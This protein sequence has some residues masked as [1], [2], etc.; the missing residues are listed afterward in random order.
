MSFGSF[1]VRP[2]DGP[3][4]LYLGLCRKYVRIERHAHK[5]EDTDLALTTPID[6]DLDNLEL[7][8]HNAAAQAYIERQCAPVR[9]ALPR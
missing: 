4:R 3:G 1:S 9:V 5:Y 2:A 7:F 8:H 6:D